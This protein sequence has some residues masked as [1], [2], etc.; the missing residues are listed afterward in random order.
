[1]IL[2]CDWK[3]GYAAKGLNAVFT[4]L[5]LSDFDKALVAVYDM[6]KYLEK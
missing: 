3:C 1:M 2:L 6:L 5:E 4:E